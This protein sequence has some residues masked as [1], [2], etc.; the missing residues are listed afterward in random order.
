MNANVCFESNDWL[1]IWKTWRFD[2][3]WIMSLRLCHLEDF[4]IGIIEWNVPFGL[5]SF[6]H[7]MPIKLVKTFL[8]DIVE[9]E[10]N[11]ISFVIFTSQRIERCNYFWTLC[12]GLIFDGDTPEMSVW[13]CASIRKRRRPIRLILEVLFYFT[14]WIEEHTE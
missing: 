11:I 14:K 6:G 8:P 4:S 10:K 9:G 3:K 12:T 2:I 5:R 7:C 1:N 13:F